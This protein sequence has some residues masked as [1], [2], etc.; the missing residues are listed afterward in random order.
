MSQLYDINW[1][2]SIR[3]MSGCGF[4][5]RLF[6]AWKDAIASRGLTQ[7]LANNAIES[8]GRLWL[9]SHGYD[10]MYDPDASGWD[11]ER[12]GYKPGPNAR[13][14]YEPRTALRMKWGE[15]GPEHLTVPGNACGLD[16]DTG[17]C[18]GVIRPKGGVLLTPHNVDCLQQASLLLTIFLFFANTLVEEMEI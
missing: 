14:M 18:L 13:K 15:W 3:E 5:I 17:I 11:Q 9:D 6:P 16:I 8:M 4:N 12:K 10:K 7:E 1:S 2:P